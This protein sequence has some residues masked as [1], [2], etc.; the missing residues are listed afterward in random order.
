MPLANLLK[1]KRCLYWDD[2]RPV[3]YAST[4][5]VPTSTLLSLC[6]GQ[7]LEVAVSQSFH[8]GNPDVRWNRG[9][10]MTAKADGL[11]D[12]MR[13][14]D[15]ED[16]RHVQSRVEQFNVWHQIVRKKFRT[17]PKCKE[18]FCWWLLQDGA[19]FAARR[20]M[21]PPWWEW[22]PQSHNGNED[23]ESADEQDE[24]EAWMGGQWQW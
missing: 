23:E 13:G 17:I 5:T 21:T 16:I 11:W 19:S 8:D 2:Y 3:E 10:V 4:G 9:A 7:Y 20:H 1:K 12:V 14:V 15:R 18:S 6:G 22:V 24:N